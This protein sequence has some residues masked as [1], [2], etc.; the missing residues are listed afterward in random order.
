[1]VPRRRPRE[2]LPRC[3]TSNDRRTPRE[4]ASRLRTTVPVPA[5]CGLAPCGGRPGFWR[6]EQHGQGGSGGDRGD[7]DQ[8][9]SV[10]DDGDEGGAGDGQHP[11][12]VREFGGGRASPALKPRGREALAG[13]AERG[14]VEG[15]RDAEERLRGAG[16]FG[17]CRRSRRQTRRRARR[18]GYGPRRRAD[19]QGC[20]EPAEDRPGG[21]HAHQARRRTMAAG[22]GRRSPRR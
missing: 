5:T 21:V 17:W 14:G 15:H 12:E 22:S 6:A 19:E 16:G 2:P 8:Q 9:H 1:M 13:G 11:G 18:R 10:A 7:D 4:S 3:R 20:V